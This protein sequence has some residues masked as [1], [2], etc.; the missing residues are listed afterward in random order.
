[1]ADSRMQWLLGVAGVLAVARLVIVPW[2][3]AQTE[4]RQQLEVLTQRLDRSEGVVANREVILAAQERL[5]KDA[6]NTLTVFP[7][8]PGDDE[9]RLAAQRRIAALANQA[10]LTVTLFDWLL[11]GEVNE[12]G[13]A[14]SRASVKLEGPLDRMILMHGELEASLPFAAVRELQ[15]RSRSAVSGPS[16]DPASAVLV[17]DLFYRPVEDA[18]PSEAVPP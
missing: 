2:A 18:A 10:G 3:E 13:L 15:V 6:E 4:Q 16:S 11:D 9:S 8:A 17:V 12:A 14:Y 1:M 5:R 7:L